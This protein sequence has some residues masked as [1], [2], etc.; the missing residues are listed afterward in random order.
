M[1]TVIAL[2]VFIVL[3]CSCPALGSKCV[4]L[5]PDSYTHTIGQQV[6][7]R[8]DINTDGNPVTGLG[9]EI[10]YDKAVL[11]KPS[12]DFCDS[13]FLVVDSDSYYTNYYWCSIPGNDG[14]SGKGLVTTFTF[15]CIGRGQAIVALSRLFTSFG[16]DSDWGV[17]VNPNP[18]TINVVPAPEP[19]SILML[20]SGL[21]GFIRF[22]RW[23]V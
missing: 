16:S 18:V 9:F 11:G 2:L 23:R 1:K 4:T 8:V 5:T 12:P 22:A 17:V 19:S 10:Y 3:C 13:I 6:V 20:V 15:D 21:A 14:F 7:V